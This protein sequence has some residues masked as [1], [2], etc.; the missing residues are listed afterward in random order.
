MRCIQARGTVHAV[1]DGEPFDGVDGLGDADHRNDGVPEEYASNDQRHSL[2][3]GGGVRAPAPRD[4]P[5]QCH[6]QKQRR[7]LPHG[8]EPPVTR[9][10]LAFRLRSEGPDK[11]TVLAPATGRGVD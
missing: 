1:V 10:V 4:T 3:P 9:A 8:T 11:T 2:R 7:E 6:E 5:Q